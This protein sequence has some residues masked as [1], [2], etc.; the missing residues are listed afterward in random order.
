[1][2]R[3][4]FKEL[5]QRDKP[6]AKA[7]LKNILLKKKKAGANLPSKEA[8][9]GMNLGQKSALLRKIAKR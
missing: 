6:K 3:G 9:S 4:S 8:L 2:A 7:I 5:I 1:M